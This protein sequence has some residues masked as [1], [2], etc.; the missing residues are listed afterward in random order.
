[1][2][3]RPLILRS[4]AT[5]AIVC[6][7]AGRLTAQAVERTDTPRRGALRVTFDPRI[8]TWEQVFTPEGRQ[9]VGAAFAGDSLTPWQ[10]ALALAQQTARAATGLAG[11][12]AR[13]GGSL[14]A[15][16]SE[17]RVTP[18]GFEYG[19]TNRLSLGATIPIVRVEVREG[20]REKPE[21]AN[22]GALADPSGYDT[23]FTS[24]STALTQLNDS[25]A[26]GAY[27][28]PSSPLCARA[29]ALFS[30][31]QTLASALASA[32]NGNPDTTA[33]FL[34]TAGSDA[35]RSLSAIVSGLSRALAD[36]FNIAAF[37]SGSFPLPEVPVPGSAAAGILDARLSASGLAPFGGSTPRHLR[38]FTGDA[39]VAA[40]YRLFNADAYAAAL[41]LVVRLPTGHQDSPNDAFDLSTG[42]H[43]TDVEGRFTGELTVWH[44]L[45]LNVSLRG[46]RQLPGQRERRIGPADQPF[47]PTTTLARLRWD[48]G[49]YVSVDV[50]PLYRFSRLFAAGVTFGYFAQ[51]QD[52][53]AFLSPQ[54]SLDVVGRTGGPIAPAVLEVGTGIRLTR[55][56]VAATFSGPRLEGGF[57][58]ERTISGAGGPVPVA[59]VFRI[60]LRQTILLF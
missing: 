18:I 4:I 45:W 28:C 54:D 17:R 7:P 12:V 5:A 20:F 6:L 43:Q 58:V 9:P 36:T 47:L 26:A 53:Y 33:M 52:R 39:E 8:T 27:G 1:M 16:R 14:L 32:V 15:I 50:A 44:R 25:I 13:L 40:K 22:V 2:R 29:Q 23:F 60:V 42:D 35:G 46:A 59:T 30:Q 56:G 24:L 38:Y 41:A 19:M 48:P 31:G 21:G 55:L 49:D 37:S 51:Q 11:Y 34:P 57:S 3:Q 10:P